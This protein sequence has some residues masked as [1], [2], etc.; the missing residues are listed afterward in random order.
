MKHCI[1]LL[2]I[3]LLVLAN[4]NK[5]PGPNPIEPENKNEILG[6]ITVAGRDIHFF[7]ARADSTSF[8]RTINND[9]IVRISGF[10][11]NRHIHLRLV[12]ITTNGTYSFQNADTTLED[13]TRAFYREGSPSNPTLFY[14]TDSTNVDIL[15]FGT[16]EIFDISATHIHAKLNVMLGDTSS[17]SKVYLEEVFI[18]GDFRD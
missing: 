17:F 7:I 12:N 8:V 15:S 2:I 16:V 1:L 6:S 11:G 9:T 13:V 5:G 14:S 18:V 4:C 10:D 3:S